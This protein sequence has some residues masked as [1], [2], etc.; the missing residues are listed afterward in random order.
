MELVPNLTGE[1]REDI[2]RLALE[3]FEV[4]D[5]NNWLRKTSQ[6]QFRPS[7]LLMKCNFNNGILSRHTTGSLTVI[8]KKIRGC[9]K[10][11]KHLHA[12]NF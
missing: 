9:S 1:I 3:G 5:E 8:L 7:I 12:S 2:A 4:D 6:L 11:Q 10:L